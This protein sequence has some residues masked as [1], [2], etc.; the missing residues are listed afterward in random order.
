LWAPQRSARCGRTSTAAH[1]GSNAAAAIYETIE[2]A[3]GQD[4]LDLGL[5]DASLAVLARRIKT[6]EI[7]TLD[8]RHFRVLRPLTG[9]DAYRSFPADR[10]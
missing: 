4:R 7:A 2:V 6:V 5:A 8:E 1:T 9:E 3:R 10:D